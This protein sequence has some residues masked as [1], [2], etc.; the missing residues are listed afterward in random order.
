[1]SSI[2]AVA[3]A[4]L[5]S[6]RHS[7]IRALGSSVVAYRSLSTAA[8]LIIALW[9]YVA[10]A[11]LKELDL[12]A[13]AVQGRVDLVIQL[14]LLIVVSNCFAVSMALK[15]LE[16]DETAFTTLLSFMPERPVIRRLA[17]DSPALMISVLVS[18]LMS[19]P[20]IVAAIPRLA[21]FWHSSLIALLTIELGVSAIL[22]GAS[23]PRIARSLLS[24]WIAPPL[25]R[26]TGVLLASSALGYE[27]FSDASELSS[28]TAF[29][30][31]ISFIG[32]AAHGSN[33]V[34]ATISVQ[35]ILI[36]AGAAYTALA[37]HGF[38][39]DSSGVNGL[40]MRMRLF[41]GIPST[42]VRTQLLQ[43]IRTPAHLSLAILFVSAAVLLASSSALRTLFM[44]PM[45]AGALAASGTYFALVSYGVTWRFHWIYRANPAKKWGWIPS[46]WMATAGLSATAFVSTLVLLAFSPGIGPSVLSLLSRTLMIFSACMVSGAALPADERQPLSALISLFF[47]SASVLALLQAADF[48]SKGHW[49]PEALLATAILTVSIF[50]YRAL[51]MKR[52]QN[53]AFPE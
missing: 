42:F 39:E 45:S 5:R 21:A 40:H 8:L 49:I 27:V 25:A 18:A 2:L 15:L 37:H 28:G 36:M 43:L 44:W 33:V 9:E 30:A 3:R 52:E 4:V 16:N 38:R 10:F 20:F 7:T 22:I 34:E 35:G 48:I 50:I 23:V 32:A 11:A 46:M 51:V 31:F 19:F 6:W 53:P 12:D 24:T 14:A 41:G 1:M 26:A 17:I 13:F 47:T 29:R